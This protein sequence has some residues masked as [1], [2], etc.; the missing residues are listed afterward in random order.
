MAGYSLALTAEAAASWSLPCKIAVFLP[1][2]AGVPRIELT[3]GSTRKEKN[4]PHPLAAGAA[5]V[6]LTRPPPMIVI[7]VNSSLD[8]RVPALPLTAPL[9]PVGKLIWT[10]DFRSRYSSCRRAD[11]V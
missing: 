9:V 4:P 7:R 10:G 1:E 3:S 2:A 6:L 8:D 5:S 11:V